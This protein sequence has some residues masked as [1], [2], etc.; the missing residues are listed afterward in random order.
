MG[1]ATMQWVNVALSILFTSPHKLL[2][3]K[4]SAVIQ[5]QFATQTFLQS[6]VSE[7]D[8]RKNLAKVKE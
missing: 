7:C 3:L 8:G 6:S 2:Q 5:K 1:F 4:I